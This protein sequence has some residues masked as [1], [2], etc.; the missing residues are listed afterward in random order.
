MRE[1]LTLEY[2]AFLSSASGAGLEQHRNKIMNDHAGQYLV[3]AE[4]AVSLE[5]KGCYCTVGGIPYATL[6]KQ[7]TKQSAA[8]VAV[9]TCAAW[10]GIQAAAPN[11]THSVAIDQ[12]ITDKPIIKIPGCPPIPEVLTNV[13]MYYTLFG[14]LPSLDNLRRPIQFYGSKIHDTC[15]RKPFFEADQYAEQYDD[16]ACKA[17]WCLYKLGCRGPETFNSC[18]SMGWWQGMSFP[19]KSGSPCIGCSA[20]NFWDNQPFIKPI[21]G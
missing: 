20:Q 16:D 6:L 12:I 11:P 21:Y 5:T 13:I 4:G 8:I 15:C 14:K 10:G 9:G 18:A 19:I 2:S 1:M 7:V 17:G 3:I